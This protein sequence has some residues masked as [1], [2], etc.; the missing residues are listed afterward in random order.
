MFQFYVYLITL[1]IFSSSQI[2]GSQIDELTAKT[3]AQNWLKKV[4][5]GGMQLAHTYTFNKDNSPLAYIFS[6]GDHG[7]VII[8]A[9]SLHKPVIAYSATSSLEI[10]HNLLSGPLGKLIEI[11]V[12]NSLKSD[13]RSD[14]C[15]RLWADILEPNEQL[16]K[17]AQTTSVQPLLTAQ[18]NQNYP[19]NMFCPTVGGQA[20]YA[21]CV[22]V[23]LAQIMHYYKYPPCGIGNMINLGLWASFQNTIYNWENMP[24]TV[25]DDSDAEDVARLIFHVGMACGTEFGT[26]G[27]GT[28]IYDDKL[29]ADFFGYKFVRQSVPENRGALLDSIKLLLSNGNPVYMS[30]GGH[31]FVIDGI[32]ESDLVHV[33]WGWSGI[34]DG[35][36]DIE[37]LNPGDKDFSNLNSYSSVFEPDVSKLSPK[38]VISRPSGSSYRLILRPSAF[39]AAHDF[40]K[41]YHN[42]ELIRD[43]LKANAIAVNDINMIAGDSIGISCVYKSGKE[44]EKIKGTI[45]TTMKKLI[46][47]FSIDKSTTFEGWVFEPHWYNLNGALRGRNSASCYTMTSVY[48]PTIEL[49]SSMKNA[50]LQ[51]VWSMG[52]YQRVNI[53]DTLYC[54]ILSEDDSIFRQ[55]AIHNS[56]LKNELCTIDLSDYIGMD[57]I[58]RW[59]YNN[60]YTDVLAMAGSEMNY[61]QVDS[62]RIISD[63]VQSGRDNPAYNNRYSMHVK[64]NRIFIKMF[65][66]GSKDIKAS[67]FDL[68]GRIIRKMTFSADNEGYIQAGFPLDNLSSG[69]YYF[70]IQSEKRMISKAFMVK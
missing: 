40:F 17:K 30:G 29:V 8:A 32:D 25:T 46:A 24:P 55:I 37:V 12:T 57:V 27:S 5:S 60:E 66:S 44:S 13:T 43:S 18:W 9:T 20:T 11:S 26:G 52:K 47:P 19:Y 62:I 28:E 50:L 6:S 16:R 67:L 21:G 23:A 4:G 31:A 41:I 15:Q 51:Y 61:V 56:L 70:R 45:D 7:F 48:S 69:V 35:Y 49:N 64:N 58:L 42:D 3:A 39:E 34:Y 63:I 54:E 2:L 53:P 10:P 33:N 14:Y 38:D 68:K 36:Y 1:I 65:E 59:R 22:P